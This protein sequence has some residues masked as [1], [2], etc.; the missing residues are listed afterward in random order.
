MHL[1]FAKVRNKMSL[2]ILESFLK[3]FYPETPVFPLLPACKLHV[4]VGKKGC[5]MPKS[6]LDFMRLVRF[7]H[8]YPGAVIKFNAP[9]QFRDN[10]YVPRALGELVKIVVSNPNWGT[11]LTD[12]QA[13]TLCKDMS[14]YS[15]ES[16]D[17]W[18]LT[19]LMKYQADTWESEAMEAAYPRWLA[20]DDSLYSIAD[21]TEEVIEESVDSKYSSLGSL[22]KRRAQAKKLLQDLG[23]LGASRCSIGSLVVEVRE[24]KKSSK[25]TRAGNVKSS[26]LYP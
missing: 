1:C 21:A 4:N 10:P 25:L 22:N 2:G 15:W 12:V 23:L 9:Y 5:E 8:S 11:S 16:F 14:R 24:K 17:N 13:V 3:T 20:S 18:R 6:G 19:F 7:L 26:G